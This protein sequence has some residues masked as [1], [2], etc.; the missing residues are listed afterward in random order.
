MSLYSYNPFKIAAALLHVS[1]RDKILHNLHFLH[2]PFDQA[3]A[4]EQDPFGWVV[5]VL[6]RLNVDITKLVLS[7]SPK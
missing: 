5:P 1:T 3:F 2:R 4:D 7:Q 6:E